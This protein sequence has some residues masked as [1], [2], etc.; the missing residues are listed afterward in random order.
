[1]TFVKHRLNVRGYTLVEI[2]IVLVIAGLMMG[3]ALK[4]F[5]LF[6]TVK[7]ADTIKLIQDIASA[8][9]QFR[10]QYGYLPGDLP[11]AKNNFAS[12]SAACDMTTATQPKIGN[13]AL[14]TAQ[15]AV[16]AIEELARAELIRATE[17]TKIEVKYACAKTN[18]VDLFGATYARS[19]SASY[20][21]MPTSI[22]NVIALYNLPCQ[23]AMEIE[24][25]YDDNNLATGNYRASVS[26]CVPGTTN[27]PVPIFLAPLV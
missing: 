18:C 11:S 27:D 21:L 16:C 23:I 7:A 20:P 13:G 1:M 10:Q 25:K 9:Q 5:G 26:S 14:D 3:L 2:G 22:R 12:L 17:F 24:L 4:Q 6:D 8:A 19:V 15:E